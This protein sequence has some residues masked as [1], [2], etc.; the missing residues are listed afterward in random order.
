[1]KKD[2]FKYLYTTLA[3]LFISFSLASCSDDDDDVSAS[4]DSAL[5]GTWYQHYQ[6]SYGYED[7]TYNT[8][9]SDGTGYSKERDKTNGVWSEWYIEEFKWEV[10]KGILKLTWTDDEYEDEVEYLNYK[11]EGNKLYIRDVDD[12]DYWDEWIRK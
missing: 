3:L 5:V 8:L 7:E 1:M 11:I 2:L 4:T 10:K 6:G 9:K 12:D